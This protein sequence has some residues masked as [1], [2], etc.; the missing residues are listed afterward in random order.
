MGGEMGGCMSRPDSCL[1]GGFGA[2]KKKKCGK[3][4]KSSIKKR[5]SF[6]SSDRSLDKADKNFALHPSFSNPTING[7][8]S[9]Y[10]NMSVCSIIVNAF[11]PS[12][13][14]VKNF[15]FEV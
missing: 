10:V 8:C 2:D 1:G 7:L 11:D 5:V 6:H 15:F 12:I 9:V 14:E 13:S 3:R 4:R